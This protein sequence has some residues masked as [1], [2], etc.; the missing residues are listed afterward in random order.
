MVIE[1]SEKLHLL[2]ASAMVDE[3]V[4]DEHIDAIYTGQ[5]IER[6]MNGRRQVLP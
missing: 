2:G 5:G 4:E 6:G 3:I 1:T